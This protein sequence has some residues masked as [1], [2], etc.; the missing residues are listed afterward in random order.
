MLSCVRLGFSALVLLFISS[1]DGVRIVADSGSGS[2]IVTPSLKN[3]NVSCGDFNLNPVQTLPY[4]LQNTQDWVVMGSSSAAG[5]GASRPANSWVGLLESELTAKGVRIHNIAKGGHTT[6]HALSSRCTV[7]ANRF[8]PDPVHN[9]DV[10]LSLNPDLVILQYPSNDQALDYDEQE[11]VVNL[12]RLRSEL[13]AAG[14]PVLILSSQPRNMALSRQQKLV[15]FNELMQPLAQPC[16]A[17]AFAELKTQVATLNP[18]YDSGDG[19]H[20]N[21]A[22]HALIFNAVMNTLNNKQCIDLL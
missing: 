8:Q 19:V 6:Y 18:D 3:D 10:A 9:I 20:V 22:G 7:S 16:F 5:A 13:L 15:R 14:V 17:S 1:C 2:I 21:D 12:L 11:P 4:R